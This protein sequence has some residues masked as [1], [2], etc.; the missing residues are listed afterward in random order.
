MK[1][2][3]LVS[4]IISLLLAGTENKAGIRRKEGKNDKFYFLNLFSYISLYQKVV[5][6]D[7]L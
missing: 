2:W 4:R 3:I 7:I 6:S 5:L 1:I